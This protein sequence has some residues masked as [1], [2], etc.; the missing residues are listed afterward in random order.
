MQQ[1]RKMFALLHAVLFFMQ[2]GFTQPG[3]PVIKA[4]SRNVDVKD[5]DKL[6]K[7]EWNL[8][9]EIRPD[10]YFARDPTHEKKITF[11]TDV[12]SISFH[13]LPGMN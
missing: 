4:L 8:S 6:L 13:V 3:I 9:P 5:G 11:Y 12:D 10:I 7:N 2:T 1:T